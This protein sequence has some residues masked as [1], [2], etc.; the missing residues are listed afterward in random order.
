[1]GRRMMTFK[2]GELIDWDDCGGGNIEI[3]KAF[4]KLCLVEDPIWEKI[5][6]KLV[7]PSYDIHVDECVCFQVQQMREE[8]MYALRKEF[9]EHLKCNALD[10]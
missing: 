5:N 7:K 2:E 6:T 10:P 4:L 9:Q 1:M 8:N 3:C